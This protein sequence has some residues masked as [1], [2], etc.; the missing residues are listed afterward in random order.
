MTREEA[1]KN[2]KE[3]CYFASL[4]PKAKE[5][6]D[7]AIKALEQEST[8]KN[9]LGVDCI[10]RNRAI[11]RL[12]LNFPSSEGAD[13]SRNRHRYMQTL[14]DLQVIRELPTVTPQEPFINKPCVFKKQCEHDKNVILDKIRAEIANI[15]L[16]KVAT[17]YEDRF[18]GFQQE[19]IK[20]LDKCKAESEVIEN[21]NDD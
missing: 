19:V 20:I 17:K 3:H 11:E 1:I 14:A 5:A 6:L 18:Y 7:L 4:I 8:T 10:D 21:G 9:A 16:N 2:I 15:N 12:K 13:N